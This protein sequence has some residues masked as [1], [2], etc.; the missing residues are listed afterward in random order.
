MREERGDLRGGGEVQQ[1]QAQVGGAPACLGPTA[2]PR[3]RSAQPHLC[4]RVG[5]SGE[6]WYLHDLQARQSTAPLCRCALP[7]CCA[8]VLRLRALCCAAFHP[9]GP[10]HH[11]PQQGQGD[12]KDGEK[13]ARPAGR[14]GRSRNQD[15][16]IWGKYAP[17]GVLWCLHDCTLCVGPARSSLHPGQ[18]RSVFCPAAHPNPHRT[19]PLPQ[20]QQRVHR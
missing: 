15:P 9:L 8:A 13:G 17:A 5:D 1:V 7:P 10:G 18:G 2:A 11:H 3:A 4:V 6:A 12:L 16:G 19:A 14:R 20:Q